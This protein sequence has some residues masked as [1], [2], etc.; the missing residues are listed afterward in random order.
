MSFFSCPA[1]NLNFQGKVK[2]FKSHFV[3]CVSHVSGVGNF[4]LLPASEES[5]NPGSRQLRNSF[6]VRGYLKKRGK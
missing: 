3:I 2:K 4:I 1:V 6:S 5:K